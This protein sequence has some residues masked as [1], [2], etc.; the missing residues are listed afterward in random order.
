MSA[1]PDLKSESPAVRQNDRAN[2]QK[3]SSTQDNTPSA[4]NLQDSRDRLTGILAVDPGVSGAVAI[5]YPAVGRISVHDTPTVDGDVDAVTLADIISSYGPNFA[6]IERVHSL[7]KQGVASTF[8][9]GRAFGSVLG[10]IAALKIPHRL[11]TPTKWKA[12][13]SLSADKEQARS[14]ALQIFPHSASH[15]ARKR[16]HNRAEACLLAKYAADV[17]QNGGGR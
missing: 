3:T 5:Y 1:P 11:V 12:H 8:R 4:P 7:P 10:V 17:F 9:F 2:Q 14:L 15:L 6:I 16:D 13:F